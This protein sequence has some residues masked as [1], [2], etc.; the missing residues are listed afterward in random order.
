MPHDELPLFVLWEKTVGDLLDRTQRFPKSVR[1]TFASRIDNLAL[2]ILEHIVVAC[3]SP[4]AET[5]RVLRDLDLA[6]ARL[7]VL[8]RLAC[9]R[10]FLDRRG[11]EHV[12]RR[13]DEAGRMV[14]G[15]RRQGTPG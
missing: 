14:G 1:F 4:P 2:D 7:R 3:Y 13:V 10:Q 5:R 11:F 12:M 9:E 6:L 8:L 15:W